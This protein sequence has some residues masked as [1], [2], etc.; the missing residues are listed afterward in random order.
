MY[1]NAHIRVTIANKILET[2]SEVFISNDKNRI[3]STCVITVP[4]NSRIKIQ[5]Q[6]V[7]E[8]SLNLFKKGDTVKV[9]AW[10]D[11]YE[12][13]TEFEGY[14]YDYYEGTPLQIRCL[15]EMFNLRFPKNGNITYSSGK[16]VVKASTVF[17]KIL[18]GT[19]VA[20]MSGN[21][22][23]DVQNLR[24]TDA[25]PE[26][27]L[28]YFRKELHISMSLFGKE[29]Y[30]NYARNIRN[31]VKLDSSINVIEANLQKP[32]TAF[33]NVQLNVWGVD[34]KGRRVK[35]QAG[36]PGGEVSEMNVSILS[37]KNK[38]GVDTNTH[39]KII[40]SSLDNAKMNKYSGKFVTM[41]YPKIDL[42]DLIDY[43]DVRYPERTDKYISQSVETTINKNGYLRTVT[44]A[45]IPDGQ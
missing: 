15:D 23:F 16:N 44:V 6:Y 35:Y 36:T 11:D 28:E 3:G 41:L 19:G 1:V 27:C 8:P 37:S 13:L 10:Y 12:T 26:A 20:L 33:Q 43:N 5:D 29:L 40:D 38:N 25:S 42:F 17:T 32:E 34:D 22:D 2:L 24:F 31:T 4:L 45:H 39:K 14:V 7:I 21:C 9:E 18:K 30:I